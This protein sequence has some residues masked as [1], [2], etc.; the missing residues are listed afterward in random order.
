MGAQ[1]PEV[2]NSFNYIFNNDPQLPESVCL[3]LLLLLLVGWG[4][5]YPGATEAAAAAIISVLGFRVSQ[6]VGAGQVKQMEQ[7]NK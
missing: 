4:S 1:P 6:V 2:M 3:V 7:I 5:V